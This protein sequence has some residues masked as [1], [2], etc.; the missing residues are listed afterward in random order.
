MIVYNCIN[1]RQHR[2]NVEA[3]EHNSAPDKQ[4]YVKLK[5][6]VVQDPKTGIGRNA[7]KKCSEAQPFL[8]SS[9]VLLCIE[10]RIRDRK[11][12]PHVLFFML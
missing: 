12:L 4:R 10:E 9:A 8:K 6:K 2:L 1:D 11:F 3:L 5:I 7:V